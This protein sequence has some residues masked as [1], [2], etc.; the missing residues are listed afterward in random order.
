M[1]AGDEPP[2]MPFILGNL[3]YVYS[4]EHFA[5]GELYVTTLR[6]GTHHYGYLENIYPKEFAFFVEVTEQRSATAALPTLT[7]GIT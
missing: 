6:P 7:L 2:F 1:Y 5:E 4:E 3:S